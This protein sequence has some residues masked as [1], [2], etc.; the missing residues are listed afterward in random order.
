[1]TS[2]NHIK[3]DF[4]HEDGLAENIGLDTNTQPQDNIL[5]TTTVNTPL[6]LPPPLT[7]FSSMVFFEKF[8]VTAAFKAG[9]NKIYEFRRL[10]SFFFEVVN[11]IP[12]ANEIHLKIY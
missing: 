6:P 5:S 4:S 2:S 8:H 9:Y 1:M 3:I 10:K 7:S 11:Q 12:D